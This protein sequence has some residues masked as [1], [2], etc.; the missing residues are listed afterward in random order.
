MPADQRLFGPLP[1]CLSF[2]KNALPLLRRRSSGLPAEAGVSVSAMKWDSPSSFHVSAARREGNLLS[3]PLFFYLGRSIQQRRDAPVRRGNAERPDT[4]LPVRQ[5]RTHGSS[6]LC[7][8]ALNRPQFAGAGVFRGAVIFRSMPE[9]PPFWP[10]GRRRRDS[11]CCSGRT[12]GSRRRSFRASDSAPS[13][14]RRPG[15][16]GRNIC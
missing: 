9:F 5:H 14:A 15:G 8:N 12:A 3:G 11:G 6:F 2:D 4:D 16:T 1:Q 10:S 13:Q 7:L